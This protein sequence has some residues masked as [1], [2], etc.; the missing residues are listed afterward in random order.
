MIKRE[1]IVLCTVYVMAMFMVAMDTTIV[2]IA[3]PTISS[4]LQVRPASVSMINIGYLVSL[5]I[6]LPTAGW[7]SQR[8]GS[9]KVFFVALALFSTSSLFCA[10]AGNIK[11]L[12]IAR[13]AQG[14]AGAMIAPIGMAMIY[15]TFTAE[16]RPQ[17]ARMLIVPMALAPA[18]GPVVGGVIIEEFTWRWIF[19]I[20]IPISAI[21]ITLG[22]IYL[23]EFTSQMEKKFD[24]RG[25]L[26][27]CPGLGL[28]IFGLSQ[29]HVFGWDS[30][31]IATCTLL[32]MC[33]LLCWMFTYQKTVQPLLDLS[34]HSDRLYRRMTF[35]MACSQAAL[36]GFLFA[37]P[38]MYQR[39]MDATAL[40]AGLIIFPEALGLMLASQLVP[41]SN[42]KWGPR[43]VI[44]TGLV[45]TIF[46]LISLSQ[47]TPHTNEWYLRG[48]L[49]LIGFFLGHTVG[50]IQVTAFAR[51]QNENMSNATTLFQVQ[52]R[53]SSAMGIALLAFVM[54]IG[55]ETMSYS[56][57]LISAACVLSIGLIIA[58]S[59]KNEDTDIV[60][61]PSK[62]REHIETDTK[63]THSQR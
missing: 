22:V 48:F 49:F 54:E 31:I 63:T 28:T 57:A 14:A 13:I 52:N 24:F 47:I 12:S 6:F 38:L 5:A 25:F 55:S 10:L 56:L 15:R 34:A 62:E 27:L 30:P 45:V 19:I 44:S 61:Q 7:L 21:A 35:I 3:I 26:L 29:T 46:I 16:E 8:F 32:G 40:E 58:Q 9:K 23:Q 20:N 51:I 43:L 18:L 59:I 11:M 1:R 42:K 17:L 50:T 2:N 4:D 33:L 53:T 37:F 39:T 41:L 36:H 60:F